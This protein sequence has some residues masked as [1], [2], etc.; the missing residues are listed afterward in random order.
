MRHS[1]RTPVALPLVALALAAACGS[2]VEDTRNEG[3]VGQAFR[4]ASAENGVPVEVL[5]AIGYVES[6]WEMVVPDEAEGM[7]PSHWGVMGLVEGGSLD[8]TASLLGVSADDLKYDLDANIRG[9]AGLLSV[10]GDQILGPTYAEETDPEMWLDVIAQY[11]GFGDAGLAFAYAQD[12]LAV[13]RQGAGLTLNSGE[14][15]ELEGYAPDVA[16]DDATDT[17]Q[18]QGALT[19][20]GQ[21]LTADSSYAAAFR[22]AH[23][24]NYSRGRS[25]S[26]DTIVIH[27]VQGSY[28]GCIGWFQNPKA[29]VS[30]HYVVRSSDGQITQ[31]VKESDTAWHARS[32]NSRSI[33]IEHEGYISKPAYY[34]D[35]MYRS[36]ARLVCDI[37]RRHHIPL[38]RNHVKGHSEL[39]GNSHTDPGRYWDWTKFMQFA[40]EACGQ[41]GGSTGS[42]G[43]TSS[44]G[45]TGGTSS[46]RS[47]STGSAVLQGVIYEAPNTSARIS[48]ATVRV[49]GKTVYS[50][51]NGYYRVSVPSGTHT[52]TVSAPGY[53]SRS[54]SRQVASGTEAWGSVGLSKGT[55][56]STTSARGYLVGVVY[57]RP[58]TSHRLAGATVTLSSGDSV[59]ADSN[60]YFSF[61]LPEGTYTVKAQAGGYVDGQVSRRVIAGRTI[62]GSVGLT[63][64]SG[65]AVLSGTVYAWPDADARIPGATVTLSSGQSTTTDAAGGFRFDVAPGTY[66]LTV[67]AA[68]FNTAT[69]IRTVSISRRAPA[70]VGLTRAATGATGS[71]IGV[72]YESPD[73]AGRLPGARV[74][75]TT[76]QSAIADSNGVYQIENVPVGDVGIYAQAS[77]FATGGVRRTVAADARRWGSVGLVRGEDTSG[78]GGSGTGEEVGGNQVVL[79]SPIQEAVVGANPTFTWK[80]VAPGTISGTFSYH[81]EIVQVWDPTLEDFLGESYEFTVEGVEGGE[82]TQDFGLSLAPGS[83]TW[84]VTPV[85]DGDDPQPAAKMETFKVE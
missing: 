22:G 6:R 80:N 55:S 66:H 25:R 68:G 74:W 76:G 67:S 35:A 81:V 79:V 34:T 24:S 84:G 38:D 82:T 11:S 3:P 37:A 10:Y 78:G 20:Q 64:P 8:E 44:G 27:T 83:W 54:I 53:R 75:T 62:W 69:K 36:S 4:D 9:A 21:A 5:M 1:L 61:R 60:G 17:A 50:S 63:R 28:Y 57:E 48:G 12:V 45:S 65:E 15:V 30:A 23:T 46:D 72:I 85:A 56:T 14:V 77:G 2:G 40:R 39:S 71:L 43:G 70:S 33:G 49:A 7:A 59:R 16:Q 19:Q 26:V 51:G 18:T 31:M 41:S 13:A 47:P 73:P 29:N 52:I 42:T 58:N 32:W